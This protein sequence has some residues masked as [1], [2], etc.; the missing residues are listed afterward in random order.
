MSIIKSDFKPAWWLQ[1][2]HLQT[3]WPT[4]FRKLPDLKLTQ[5][6]LE[7]DDG[8]FLDLTWAGSEKGEIVL[9]LHGLEGSKDSPYAKGIMQALSD[10]GFSCCLMHFRGCSGKPNRLPRSYHSGETGDLQQ[11]IDHIRHHHQRNVFAAIGYSLG[12]NALLKWLGEK[13]ESAP[14]TTAV[15]VSVPFSLDDAAI[16]MGTGL[17]RGYEKHLVSRLQDKY[18][19]KFS[20]LP[21]PLEIEIDQMKTFYLF[22]DQ[23]TAPLHG[24]KDVHDYYEKSSCGQFLKNIEK[25]TLIL[26]S[27]DDP[28]MWP[29]TVPAE[30]ELSPN[31]RL[32]LSEKGGH[33]GFIGG[34]VPW[35]PKYWLDK[36]IVTWLSSQ[37]SIID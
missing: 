35:K 28:F 34:P 4:F 21:S 3:V 15:A 13:R 16:R 22:D 27:K 32:E 30:D 29:E 33:V 19:E 10:A 24:F 14:V 8:D 6:R 5:E 36:R 11:V 23:V 37:K 1:G 20:D 17:S 18:R 25:P 2:A 12:G 31:V 9:I 26:H 7:L